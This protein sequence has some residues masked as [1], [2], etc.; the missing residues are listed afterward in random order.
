MCSFYV[1][2]LAEGWTKR[3]MKFFI[4]Q[5]E[6]VFMIMRKKEIL[7]NINLYDQ[8]Q[9]QTFCHLSLLP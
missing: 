4:I 5:G 7:D 6:L 1:H 3:R 2:L 9:A 8:V